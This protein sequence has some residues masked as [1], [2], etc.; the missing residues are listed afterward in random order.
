[1]E[2]NKKRLYIEINYDFYS[3]EEEEDL[4]KMIEEIA[5]V[6]IDYTNVSGVTILP[7]GRE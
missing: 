7:I 5:D 3:D 6:C 2:A 1:M 4:E